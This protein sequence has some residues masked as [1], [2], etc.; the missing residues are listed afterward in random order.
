MTA[1]RNAVKCSVFRHVNQ[2]RL[3]FTYR[4]VEIL[5][6]P[7]TSLINNEHLSTRTCHT[8][9]GKKSRGQSNRKI[10]WSKRSAVWWGFCFVT[11]NKVELRRLSSFQSLLLPGF[12]PNTVADP[13]VQIRWGGGGAGA[14]GL[15]NPEI[16][17]AGP[18]GPLP[19]IRHWNITC[20]KYF[21]IHSF[22]YV[23]PNF[24]FDQY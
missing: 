14:D 1:T 5:A 15:R 7:T 10:Y 21:H 16:R 4:Y 9:F 24:I 23:C 3:V 19:W 20:H 2:P 18:P 12:W 6:V 8:C 11:L 22:Q 13:D 17:K